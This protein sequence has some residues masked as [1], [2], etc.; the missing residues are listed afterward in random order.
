M[1]IDPPR[2]LDQNDKM[3]A[4]LGDIAK[5]VK[6][7]VNGREQWITP[8]DYKDIFSAELKKEQRIA[9]GLSGGFVLLGLRTHKLKKREMSDLI[10]IMYAFG[11]ERGVVWSE[12]TNEGTN[13][14]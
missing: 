13:D 3:W 2:T 1:I 10:E 8:D 5:Q 4:M 11:A 7:P 14:T 9:Q 12:P 6:W